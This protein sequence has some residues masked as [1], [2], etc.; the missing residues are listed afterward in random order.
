MKEN[1]EKLEQEYAP[2]E[3]KI[4]E[5]EAEA[6]EKAERAAKEKWTE[7]KVA[8]ALSERVGLL[9]R[10]WKIVSRADEPS[11]LPAE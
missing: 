1:V 10:A 2:L 3:K 5:A 11:L 9:E 8:E 7:R 6:K 4:E